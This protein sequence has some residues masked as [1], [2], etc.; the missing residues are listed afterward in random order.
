MADENPSD[1]DAGLRAEPPIRE[2]EQSDPF[3]QTG[4][5]VKLG[6]VTLFVAGIVLILSV[7]LYGLNG[8]HSGGIAGSPASASAPTAPQ[9]TNKG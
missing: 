7:V 9:T 6:G 3:P 5:G 1:R 2:N 8:G 4:A